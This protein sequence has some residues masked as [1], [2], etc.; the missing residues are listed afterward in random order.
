MKE[1][2]WGA[3]LL[4]VLGCL[5]A[6]TPYH[7]FPVCKATVPTASG[8]AVPMKCFWTAR[9]VLGNGGMIA[10]AGLLLLFVK[11]PGVRLGAALAPFSA[12]L[13]A[14]MT[15]HGLIGVCP[16]ETMA[17]HMGTLPALTLLGSFAV[18]AAIGI[19]ARAGKRMKHPARKN[20]LLVDKGFGAW[21]GP[22]GGERA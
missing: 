17:C 22:A 6:L 11:T 1:I 13:L 9:A 19:A 10:F 21:T 4:I 8:G 7:L 15:P 18:L 5:I 2:S 20:S 3:L 16:G 14:V 12:G